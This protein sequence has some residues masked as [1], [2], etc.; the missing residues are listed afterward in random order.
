MLVRL[1]LLPLGF[2]D[3][4]AHA[5]M[6]S[7]ALIPVEKEQVSLRP[8]LILAVC[9]DQ[10]HEHSGGEDVRRQPQ[11]RIRRRSSR[12]IEALERPL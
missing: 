2:D 4:T 12:F 6:L 3:A 1:R 5:V 9:A 10:P 8:Q 7:Q 11:P